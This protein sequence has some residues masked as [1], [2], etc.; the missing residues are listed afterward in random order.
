MVTQIMQLSILLDLDFI[1]YLIVDVPGHS[2]LLQVLLLVPGKVHE[3]H[4]SERLHHDGRLRKELLLVCQGGIQL[5][6]Q[7]HRQVGKIHFC[8]SSSHSGFNQML[9][10]GQLLTTAQD[11]RFDYRLR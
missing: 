7:K 1:S 6:H 10:G 4:Q 11:Y 3:V 2:L 5:A 8:L 9:L